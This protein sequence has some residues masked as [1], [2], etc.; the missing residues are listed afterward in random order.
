MTSKDDVSTALPPPPPQRPDLVAQMRLDEKAALLT[1]ASGWTTAGVPRLGV[2]SVFMADGPHGVRRVPEVDSLDMVVALPATC[3]PTAS[4]LASSWDPDLVRTVA[5][6]IGAEARALGVDVVLG[7]GVN[8]KRSPL[9]GR[10]FE[11]FSEDPFLAGELAVAYI[12]GVQSRG[13]GACLKHFAV[14]NQET[15]RFTVDARLDQRTLREIYLPAFEAA[16]RR[17]RPWAVMCSYN[18]VNGRT[19]SENAFLLTD[20]LRGEWEFDGVVMSDWGA[21]RDRGAALA[22]GLDLEMPGPRAHRVATVAEAVREGRL[23]VDAVDAAAARLV[24]LGEL[25]AGRVASEPVDPVE[26]HE[27][28]RRAAAEGIVLLKNDGTLPLRDCARIAVVGRGARIPHYQGT[29][30]S[31]I[32]PTQVVEPLAEVIL[33]AGDAVVEYAD[34]HAD[35]P[36]ER[37]DLIEEAI[38]AAARAD[39]AIVFAT[40]PDWKEAEGADRLDID[41]PEEQVRLIKAVAAVQPR[42]VV[43]LNNGSAVAVGE[44][45][46]DAAAVLDAWL[47][48]QAGGGAVADVLFGR[49][50]PSGKLAETFPVRLKDTPSH[51]NF[52]GDGDVVR[53]GEGPFIGY[54]WYDSRDMAVQFPFG[55]GLSYTSFEYSGLEVSHDGDVRRGLTLGLRVTNVGTSSGKEVVQVYVRARGS[56][57][58]RPDKELKGFAKVAV[59]PG[60]TQSVSISL[61]RRAFEYFDPA[62][63]W[64][65][66][67]GQYEL[68]VGA[69]SRDI[70]LATTVEVGGERGAA[71][72]SRYSTLG[73]WLEHPVGRAPALQLLEELGMP[74]AHALGSEPDDPDRLSA[75]AL[76]FL[77]SM[78]VPTV[79]E[80]AGAPSVFGANGDEVVDTMLD[81]VIRQSVDVEASYEPRREE[82]GA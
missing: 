23:P 16:I 15:R 64:V 56:R 7:P 37:P 27:L 45:V 76:V 22:A 52:P 62:L 80:F 47:M 1:G 74:L 70:R 38:G 55:H 5:G 17:A 12:E 54:R 21:V 33:Q 41:L 19:V 31:H 11:Y 72:L 32:T 34:G 20:I 35:G 71:E 25:V 6:A 3:F 39:V 40:L 51:L 66:D 82:L 18:S 77:E 4:S 2:E 78:P 28:A 9:C 14:N 8:M 50:N 44:W 30:S 49:V 59:D 36:E 63:G 46:D 43:V 81:Q 53:Y 68:L 60:E 73:D 29:G 42:T 75:L 57:V 58:V 13:V 10:N 65:C 24:R 67:P 61:E 69:S 79:V 26:H 48:G